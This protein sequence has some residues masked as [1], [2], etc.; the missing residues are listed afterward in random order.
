[1]NESYL[2]ANIHY[3][4]GKDE[5]EGL[6]EFYRRAHGLGLLPKVTELRFHADR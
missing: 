4:F 3:G 2:R 6:L 5:Q 1:L